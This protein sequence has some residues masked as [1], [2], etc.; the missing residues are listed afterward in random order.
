MEKQPTA[1]AAEAYLLIVRDAPAELYAAMSAE[2]RKRSMDDWNAWVDRIAARSRVLAA[3]PL[4]RTGRVVGGARGERVTDGPFAEAKEFVGGF[5]LIG[6]VDLD[7]ATALAQEC[8]SLRHGMTI[9]VRPIAGA[10]H[11]AQSLGWTTM[12]G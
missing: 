3:N 11:V 7:G 8:P 1:G 2:Q 5:F 9:E 10:C 12:R 6:G 4:E